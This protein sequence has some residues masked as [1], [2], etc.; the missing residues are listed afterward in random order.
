M[1]RQVKQ[2]A[3]LL[4]L[5]GFAATLNA[6]V[7]SETEYQQVVAERKELAKKLQTAK[8]EN[9]LLNQAV[10]EIYRE[11]E[12]LLAENKKL[13]ETLAQ[14]DDGKGPTASGPKPGEKPKYYVVQ[15]G[16]TLTQ[17]AQAHNV[18]PEELVNWHNLRTMTVLVGQR[19]RVR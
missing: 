8:D 15:P 6:C 7:V 19:L 16:D 10:L 9:R 13:K 4:I 2:A 1:W 14:T 3:A 11:R 5:A 12:R 18:K 17:I